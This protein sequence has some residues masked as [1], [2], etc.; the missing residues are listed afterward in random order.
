MRRVGQASCG[1]SCRCG[2][3]RAERCRG[4]EGLRLPSPTPVTSL[5]AA[6]TPVPL[7]AQVCAPHPEKCEIGHGSATN[8][9]AAARGREAA[10]GCSS[11]LLPL[12]LLSGG[13]LAPDRAR[14]LSC[15]PPAPS[16]LSSYNSRPAGCFPG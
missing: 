1:F 5:L 14:T 15:N 16:G 6:A 11:W 2:A 9:C 4:M 13:G 7:L 12:L 3:T 10:S 8:T